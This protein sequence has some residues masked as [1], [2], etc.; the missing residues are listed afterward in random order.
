MNQRPILFAGETVRL[1]MPED[2][3]NAALEYLQKYGDG[4]SEALDDR[5]LLED[6]SKLHEARVALREYCAET[7]PAPLTEREAVLLARL[8]DLMGVDDT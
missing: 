2:L 3:K 4:R 7:R 6:D 5:S 1:L 8:C